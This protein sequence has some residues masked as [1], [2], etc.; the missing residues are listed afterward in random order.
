MTRTETSQAMKK[1]V[2][3]VQVVVTLGT[4]LLTLFSRHK[5]NKA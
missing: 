5:Q 3:V 2:R 4:A 1:V